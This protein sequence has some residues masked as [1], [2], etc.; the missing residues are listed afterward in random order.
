MHL[1]SER[2]LLVAGYGLTTAHIL[3]RLPDFET[4][5]QSFI[6]QNYDVAPDFPAMRKFLKFWEENLDGPLHSVRYTHQ[7]LIGPDEC[8]Q[9][10]GELTLH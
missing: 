10:S 7:R 9:L 1:A 8:Q 2:E 5:L 3:Y 6:W 4:L